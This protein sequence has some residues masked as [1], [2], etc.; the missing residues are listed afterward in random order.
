MG[1]VGAAQPHWEGEMQL[2]VASSVRHPQHRAVCTPPCTW[3]CPGVRVLVAKQQNHLLL[4]F[5]LALGLTVI[6]W[7]YLLVQR[8][9]KSHSAATIGTFPQLL[10][11]QRPGP[12]LCIRCLKD[13]L[14]VASG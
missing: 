2:Q 7:A 14:P 6:I 10:L 3:E 1:S 5:C 11:R 9:Y 4:L 12:T 13:R 8:K